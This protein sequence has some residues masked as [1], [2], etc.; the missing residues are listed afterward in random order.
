ML[1][2]TFVEPSD[3]NYKTE[4]IS[5]TKEVYKPLF[6]KWVNISLTSDWYIP[7]SLNGSILKSQY[8]TA[9]SWHSASAVV[10]AVKSGFT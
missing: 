9:V 4:E 10:V 8:K 2:L 6:N 5:S 7:L 3:R 1:Q